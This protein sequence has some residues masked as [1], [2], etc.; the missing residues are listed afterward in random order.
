MAK[1]N[2]TNASTKPSIWKKPTVKLSAGAAMEFLIPDSST[3]MYYDTST[4][5][6]LTREEYEALGQKRFKYK[7]ITNNDRN[8]WYHAGRHATDYVFSPT[9]R[10][11]DIANWSNNT[12]NTNLSI[13]EGV[14]PVID[15][16]SYATPYY[17]LLRGTYDV[18]KR[19][20]DN[21]W[22]PHRD[23]G[24]IEDLK[25]GDLGYSGKWLLDHDDGWLSVPATG[26]KSIWEGAKT[27]FANDYMANTTDLLGDTFGI[28][29]L[30]GAIRR[31][32]FSTQSDVYK[33]GQQT[34]TKMMQK[35]LEDT[36]NFDPANAKSRGT[37][38]QFNMMNQL[39]KN[40]DAYWQFQ[41]IKESQGMSDEEFK[42]YLKYSGIDDNTY[43]GYEY[44][45][46]QLYNLG[47]NQ[48]RNGLRYDPNFNQSTQA[49]ML[50]YKHARKKNPIKDDPL[51]N[52]V[53][54]TH[55]L[56]DYTR[57]GDHFINVATGD[58]LIPALNK[59]P[60]ENQEATNTPVTPTEVS[61]TPITTEAVNNTSSNSHSTY[62]YT[63][64]NYS[65]I[66]FNNYPK[67]FARSTGYSFENN[68]FNIWK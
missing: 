29:S 27:M 22:D 37:L 31:T 11:K 20:S 4:G 34:V 16:V 66:W 61:N 13:P 15:I 36:N 43:R 47:D 65:K 44:A 50:Q 21:I 30:K 7:D 33:L 2:N 17:G 5:K 48:E 51:G 56:D 12:F 62:S 42:D 35:M 49:P 26:I 45:A 32:G 1:S 18:T 59:K 60:V 24:M 55:V 54:G 57:I 40:S 10:L 9:E 28:G 53:G 39:L 63:P 38:N 8:Y 3:G 64:A 23:I 41:G 14:E 25:Y 46:R 52:L 67:E 6:Y 58:D 19:V 68:P